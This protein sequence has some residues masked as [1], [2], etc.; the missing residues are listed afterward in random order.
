MWNKKFSLKL[1]KN[2]EVRGY[3]RELH[4]LI[5]EV[6]CDVNELLRMSGFFEH[7]PFAAMRLFIYFSNREGGPIVHYIKRE[8]ME[9]LVESEIDW[10]DHVQDGRSDLKTFFVDAVLPSVFFAAQHFHL[11]A[12]MLA[13]ECEA[14]GMDVKCLKS[15]VVSSL[16]IK[17]RAGNALSEL[18]VCIRMSDDA[19]GTEE[20][21]D[22]CRELANQLEEQGVGYGARLGDTGGGGGYYCVYLS[23]ESPREF[24]AHIEPLLMS[25][26]LPGG[27][28]VELRYRSGLYYERDRFELSD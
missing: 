11:S 7:A 22:S 23:C 25:K 19:Y 1:E 3:N 17:S 18:G 27:S 28:Y 12:L 8:N 20:E 6:E 21:R 14:N 2:G 16:P 13:A 5:E 24:Y 4:S 15:T 9:L 26:Q 10:T